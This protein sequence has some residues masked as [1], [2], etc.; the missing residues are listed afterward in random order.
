MGV[1]TA[2]TVFQDPLETPSPHPCLP[3]NRRQILK[4]QQLGYLPNCRQGRELGW[5]KWGQ[6]MAGIWRRK[7]DEDLV[8]EKA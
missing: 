5:G 2:E 7:T 1:G 4:I 3:F 6:D 8:K